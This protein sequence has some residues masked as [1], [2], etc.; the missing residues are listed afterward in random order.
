MYIFT[1]IKKYK[2]GNPVSIERISNLLKNTGI[3]IRLVNAQRVL[4]T[5]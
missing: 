2:F 4:K 5:I 3:E 1:T